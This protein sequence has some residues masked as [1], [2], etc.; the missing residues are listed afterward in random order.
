MTSDDTPGDGVMIGY[1]SPRGDFPPP[2]LGPGHLLRPGT[3]IYR[4]VKAGRGLET[5]HHVVIREE[6]ILGDMVHVWSNTVIDYGC[7]IGGRV[8]I[9]CNVYVAQFTIIED[10]VFVGPGVIFANDPHP[11][12]RHGSP[13]LAG[14]ILRR[15]CRVG[16][17]ATLLPGVEIGEEALVAAGAVVTANVPARTTV[18][19]A[20]ARSLG[21]VEDLKCRQGRER[22][23]YDL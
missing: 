18:A 19:G 5:G 7:R 22:G 12:C 9:H 16:A 20:P 8:R 15:G 6:C 4:G 1:P 23:P 17:G 13:C 2:I 3:V 14:P 11:G 10:D 21:A